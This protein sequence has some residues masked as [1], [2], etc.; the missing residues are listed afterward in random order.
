LAGELRSEVVEIVG[1]ISSTGE[2]DERCARA[3]GAVILLKTL[4]LSGGGK[5]THITRAT[6]LE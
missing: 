4:G 6:G 1:Y 2:E 5:G 3:Q